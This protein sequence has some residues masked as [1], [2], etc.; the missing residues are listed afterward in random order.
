MRASVGGGGWAV[1]ADTPQ[2]FPPQLSVSYWHGSF[3]DAFNPTLVQ[4]PETP[5]GFC[6]PPGVEE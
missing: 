2:I 4:N 6:S 5:S 1:R 3:N